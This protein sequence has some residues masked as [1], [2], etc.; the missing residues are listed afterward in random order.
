M[1]SE[2]AVAQYPPRLHNEVYPFIYPSKFRGSLQ[3]KV[4]LITGRYMTGVVIFQG[5]SQ[6]LTS[7]PGSAG[8]IGQALAES[9]AVA[10]A[11]LV[12]VYNRTK[13]PTELSERCTRF[14]ASAVTFVQCNV[15]DLESCEGLVKQVRPHEL[16]RGGEI[17]SANVVTLKRSSMPTAEWTY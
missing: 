6:L 9:F 7:S 3:G 15:S 14:G 8:T 4:T 11:N 2:P 16:W 12:L 1:P 10:G 13:P 5:S 17:S